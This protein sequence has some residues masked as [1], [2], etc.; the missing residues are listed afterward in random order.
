[1]GLAATNHLHLPSRP[2]A[3]RT[4][5]ARRRRIALASRAMQST[6]P[7]R[8]HMQHPTWPGTSP[9]C[10][11]A[12]HVPPPDVCP[13]ARRKLLANG[14]GLEEEGLPTQ[15]SLASVHR[16]QVPATR[17]LSIATS[18]QQPAAMSGRGKGGAARPVATCMAAAIVCVVVLLVAASALLFLLSS[19]PPPATGVPGNGPPREPVEL[20]I[21]LAGHERWLDAL[22]A[23]AKLACF[24]LRRPPAEPR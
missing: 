9:R 16:F 18:L 21:G 11:R 10:S 14:A 8:H 17:R 7:P 6:P 22:R 4:L 19:S 15:P 3:S 24:N 2:A 1:M 12:Q 13:P 23:W 20:A 5:K